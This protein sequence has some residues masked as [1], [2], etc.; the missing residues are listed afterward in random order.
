MIRS[1]KLT[2]GMRQLLDYL[3]VEG[4]TCIIASDSNTFFIEEILQEQ[5]LK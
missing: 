5:E 1:A 2:D 4:F 3:K